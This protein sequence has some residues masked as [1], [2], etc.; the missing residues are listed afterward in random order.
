MKTRA[1][2]IPFNVPYITGAET[3][4]VADSLAT[5]L[6]T[7]DGPFTA[8]A[9][10][11][12]SLLVGGAPCLLTTSCTHALEMAALLLD[13]EP[14]DEVIMPSFTFVSTANAFVLRGAVP[15]FVD[16]RSDTLCVD[17]SLI[18]SAIT[19]RTRAIVVVHYGGFAA[20]MDAILDI[21]QQHGLVV[22]ED[23]A[24][25]L[26][27]DYRGRPLGSLGALATQSFHGT[28]NIQCGE[29]G[30]L[31]VNDP[32]YFDRAEMIREKG[33]NR[34]QY[35]R[36]QVDK[37]TWVDLGSSYLPSDI[38]AA[39]LTA[40]LEAFDDIQALRHSVWSRY[41]V[42]LVDWAQS[43]G[44]TG[45]V[46]LVDQGHPAH[47]FF[48]MMPSHADQTGLINHL[49]DHG[50]L[51][52]FHYV[53]LD[54]SPSGLQFGRSAPGG[55]PVTQSVSERL[56]RLPVYAGISRADVARVIDAVT[57]YQFVR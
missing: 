46:C 11:R 32:R 52:T 9:S 54:S 53:P 55:C 14:G 39:V 47:L 42:S 13:L 15:V 41:H 29:G 35:F 10:Q 16:C 44:V 51:A 27:G 43:N 28:K 19:P 8:R 38:N 17:E 4:Y 22:V 20:Q 2:D 18:E 12:L 7:G 34:N 21:A 45:S 50:I 49:A 31:V 36:G 26:G 24:H 1:F 56:V 30:A 23:N 40:Q 57:R 33:T 48:L 37:Y 6:L 25:G 5:G 3:P